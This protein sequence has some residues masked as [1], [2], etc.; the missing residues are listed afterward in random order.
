MAALTAHPWDGGHVSGA[1]QEKT[2]TRERAFDPAALQNLYDG[3]DEAVFKQINYAQLLLKYRY[4][5]AAGGLAGILLGVMLYVRSGPEYEATAQIL[6]SK[7]ESVP[8][9]EELRTLSSWGERSEHIALIMSPLILNRAV[10]LGKLDKLPIFAGSTDI[11]EDIIDDLRVKRSSGQDRSYTNVLTLTYPSKTKEDARAVIEAVIAAYDEYLQRTRNEKSVEVLSATE[12]A[13]ADV[14]KKLASKEQEYHAFRETAPLQWKAPVGA[15]ASD[16][17]TTTNVHQERVLAAEEQRR[18]NVL[19]QA[20]LQSRVKAIEMARASGEPREGLEVLIR[21]FI[22]QDGSSGSDFQQQQQ[23]DIAVFDNRILPLMLR[24]KE[25]LL[26]YGPDHPEVKL[27]RQ[28][29]QTALDFYRR[30]GIRL[31][32]ERKQQV[33]DGE[34][35]GEVDF[36]GLYAES[37]K[38]ELKELTIRDQELA[39]LV[40]DE[41]KLA[42]SVAKFQAKDEAMH[43]ELARLRDLWGQLVTQ[44]NQVGIEIEGSGYTLKQLAAVKE[45]LSMKRVAKFVGGGF[46]FGVFLVTALGLL[47]ELRDLRINSV[48]ELRRA[49]SYPLLGTITRFTTLVRLPGQWDQVPDALRYL[50]APRSS[51]AESY[52]ALRTALNITGEASGAKVIQITSPESGDGKSTTAANLAVALAQSGQRVMLIDADLRRPTMH[53]LFQISNDIG[54]VDVLNGDLEGINAARQTYVENLAVLPAGQP[55]A[56][57]AE[58]ISRPQLTKLLRQARDEYDLV[59]VDSPPLLAVSDPCALARHTDGVLLVIRLGKTSLSTASRAKEVLST[60][61][62]SVLG[63]VANNTAPDDSHAYSAKDPYYRDTVVSKPQ[64]ERIPAGV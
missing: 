18:L 58:L 14:E 24:E 60:N 3:E 33:E 36:V 7:K 35:P 29:I 22:A 42:K 19:R 1:R 51:E 12:K 55:P 61:N 4:W 38:Q 32:E 54:L 48:H 2:V 37:L 63:M 53:T 20:Q 23:Q 11:A 8:V 50:L 34:D 9:P 64:V 26:D 44:V 52:R 10:V 13:L 46:V 21:R 15:Q 25:L 45:Q 27:V 17:Q 28:S 5:I 59:I 62:V 56:N 43:A 16:G 39:H 47:R 6:V 40:E 31:P 57:P 30:Q 41:S 49:V